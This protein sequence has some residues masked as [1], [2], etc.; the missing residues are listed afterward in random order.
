MNSE[1]VRFWSNDKSVHKKKEKKKYPAFLF[2]LFLSINIIM[3]VIDI[4]VLCSNERI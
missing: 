1:C 2:F 3:F 4:A